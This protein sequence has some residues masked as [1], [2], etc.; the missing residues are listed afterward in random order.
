MGGLTTDLRPVVKLQF[1]KYGECRIPLDW[2]YS[3]AHS[4]Q[5]WLYILGSQQLIKEIYLKIVSIR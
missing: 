5:E 4:L 1:W 2:H 3:L